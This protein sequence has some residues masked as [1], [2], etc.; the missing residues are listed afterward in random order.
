MQEKYEVENWPTPLPWSGSYCAPVILWRALCQIL[1]K[2]HLSRVDKS[3]LTR[4]L[5]PNFR[6]NKRPRRKSGSKTTLLPTILAVPCALA[7]NGFYSTILWLRPLFRAVA[8]SSLAAIPIPISCLPAEFAAP[9]NLSTPFSPV[10]WPEINNAG[11][12]NS[13]NKRAG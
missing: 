9:S 5:D 10:F 1:R 11:S 13:S 2:L 6:R 8:A 3:S 12:A 7:S 4:C